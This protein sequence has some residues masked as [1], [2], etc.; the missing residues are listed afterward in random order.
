MQ[1]SNNTL[2]P[3]HRLEGR[4]FIRYL[5]NLIVKLLQKDKLGS[6]LFFF[7]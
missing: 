4:A 2:Y 7:F 6:V 3:I 5:L 1:I